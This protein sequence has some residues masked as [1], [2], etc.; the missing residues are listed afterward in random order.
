MTNEPPQPNLLPTLLQQEPP[1]G[2][3]EI[4]ALLEAHLTDQHYAAIGRI[5]VSWAFLEA[6]VDAASIRLADAIP[7]AGACLTSQ[8]ASIGRKLD[9]YIALARVQ[10]AP[11]DVVAKL[12]EFAGKP[13]TSL[14]APCSSDRRDRRL[15]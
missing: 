3:A 2:P 12:C 6:N 10:G 15:L 9:A 11:K 13:T 8:I 14:A 7:G 1:R 4:K 5:A